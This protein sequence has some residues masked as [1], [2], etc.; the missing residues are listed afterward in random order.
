MNERRLSLAESLL[1]EAVYCARARQAAGAPLASDLESGRGG[2]G[3]GQPGREHG[4]E[5]TEHGEE[6]L[7]ELFPDRLGPTHLARLREVVQDWVASS[8]ALD[9]KRNHFL[10]DFRGLHGFDRRAYDT[11]IA[12]EFEE[13]LA[14]VNDEA[15]QR[16][17]VAAEELLRES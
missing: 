11:E 10:R 6:L 13:G 3:L 7:A 4:L 12:R 1:Q 9:R 15:N 17:R 8:D 2:C 14:R 16:L 5:L